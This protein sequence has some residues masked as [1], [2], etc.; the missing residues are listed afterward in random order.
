MR[1]PVLSIRQLQYQHADGRRLDFM[2]PLTVFPGQAV[3][4]TGPSGSGKSTFLRALAGCPPEGGLA[5]WDADLL[6]Q[7]PALS[8]Q[9]PEA[10]LLCASVEEEVELGPRNQGISGAALNQRIEEALATLDITA[11]RRR[12]V[13]TLSMGQKQRVVLAALLA[14]RPDVLLFDEPFSQLDAAGEARLRSLIARLK[15]EGRVVIVSAHEA[16][17][18]DPLWDIRLQLPMHDVC[19]LN[20]SLPPPP[21]PAPRSKDRAVPVLQ[22]RGLGFRHEAGPPVFDDIDLVLEPGTTTQVAGGNAT[23][24]STLLRCLIGALPCSAG[25]VVIDGVTAP[26]PGRLAARLG[27]LPQNADMLLFE[28][29]VR[30]EIAFTLRRVMPSAAARE[31][32]VDEILRFCGLTELAPRPPLCLSHG[33][34]HTLALASLLAARPAVL[35]LDEPLTGLDAPVATILLDLLN[36]FAQTYGTAVLLAT[37]GRLPID[38]GERRF[39]LEQGRFH[40]VV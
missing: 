4:M 34:R 8:L 21:P 36:H 28:E 2:T 32:R 37:H 10:Q 14:M 31:H 12:G 20:P 16:H 40:A 33:E 26:K 5:R 22:A 23:G 7:K 9:D 18:E 29:S 19:R 25:Q 24:K 13:H 30:R 27:Y 11:L 35:L 6:P 17:P 15:A 3:I 1:S 39:V 38:W